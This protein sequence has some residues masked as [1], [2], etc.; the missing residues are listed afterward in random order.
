MVAHK[1]RS[2]G[3]LVDAVG[4]NTVITNYF[5]SFD[6]SNKKDPT[7]AILQ[8]IQKQASGQIQL[9]ID[10]QGGTYF[11]VAL[12]MQTNIV[13]L[14][15]EIERAGTNDTLRASLENELEAA[16]DK[17]RI[18]GQ[19]AEVMRKRVDSLGVAEPIIQPMT[20]D[21][22]IVIQLPGLGQY[23]LS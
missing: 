10:L 8:R 5:P 3:N 7:R 15:K 23:C 11:V 9:G 1:A 17:G 6:V 12:N 2:Y 22:R 16:N 4:A 14:Q 21:D 20:G 13:R 18:L 19:A